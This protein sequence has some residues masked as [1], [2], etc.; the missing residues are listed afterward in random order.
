[1]R[2]PHEVVHSGY[3]DSESILRILRVQAP[4]VSLLSVSDDL[5]LWRPESFL[6]LGSIQTPS[7]KLC[8]MTIVNYMLA[9]RVASDHSADLPGVIGSCW[10]Y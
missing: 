3:L 7:R 4:Y 2:S 6:V 8:E 10:I 1:M 5:R 9:E